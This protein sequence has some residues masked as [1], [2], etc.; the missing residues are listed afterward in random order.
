MIASLAAAAASSL[1]LL[2]SRK[3]RRKAKAGSDGAASACRD[4]GGSG[5]AG[6]A[7]ARSVLVTGGAGFIGSHTVLQLLNAGFAVTVVDNL[8]NARVECLQRVAALA[9]DAASRLRFFCVDMRNEEAMSAVFERAGPFEAVI[10]FAG[11]KAVGDSVRQPLAYYENNVGGTVRLLQVMARHGC[12][13][14]VFSSSATVYGPA[15][16]PIAETA[17][18]GQGI[19]NA[20]GRTKYMVEEIMKDLYKSDPSWGIVLLRY[21][22][23]IGAHPSGR[24]GEDPDKP[25]NL[26]PYILQV[27]VG[28]RPQLT[29]F[30]DDYDTADGTGVRDYL[31]VED[32]ATGH[33]A[34]LDKLQADSSGCLVY[35][36]G[37]GKGVSVLDMVRAT[38]AVTGRPLPY[39]MGKRRAGDVDEIYA[40]ARR[41]KDELG[42]AATRDLET[43][44]KDAVRW[45]ETNPTG[46][47]VHPLD[48]RATDEA[49]TKEADVALAAAAAAVRMETTEEGDEAAD[50]ADEREQRKA[51]SAAVDVMEVEIVPA[52]E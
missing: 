15:R 29:V 33:L 7:A 6:E 2:R 34:A 24:I 12:K 14:I 18:A 48:H 42:W 25:N 9:G 26:M 20:Y 3:K 27:L 46:F 28:R 52:V 30:G 19:T 1:V 40:D 22:N 39:V 16:V 17:V 13:R 44:V 50:A 36:L 4:G 11:L 38:E 5:A 21:F 32:L 37:T 45:Q 41:A 31:H 10:H 35:N 8:C 49:L 43:M 23:P 47:A 51:G